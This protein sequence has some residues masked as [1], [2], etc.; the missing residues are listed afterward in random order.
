VQVVNGGYA[1]ANAVGSY[2]GSGPLGCNFEGSAIGGTQTSATTVSGYKGAIM[3][4]NASM[5]VTAKGTS[6]PQ[7]SVQ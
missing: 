3:T 6:A 7:P 2:S 1:S 5:Q 4:S